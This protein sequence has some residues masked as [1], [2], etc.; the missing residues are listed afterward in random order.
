MPENKPKENID[1][2]KLLLEWTFPEYI[3]HKRGKAW[4]FWT[5]A[6]SLAL[7]IWS[8]VVADY[9]YTL[10]I[11]AIGLIFLLQNKRAPGLLDCRI[12][13]DGLEIGRNFYAFRDIKKFY[14]IYRPPEVKTI[15][16]DFKTGLR[17]TLPIPLESQNP[18][19][20]REILKKYL[21]EDL[22]KEEEPAADA[23]SRSLKI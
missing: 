15:Y 19:K 10:I 13:E 12:K 17:P 5:L 2:G 1:H 22:E 18:I 6:I 7:F 21:D 8:I 11:V 14:L 9:L 4:Y 16:L 20:V 3:P 23:I